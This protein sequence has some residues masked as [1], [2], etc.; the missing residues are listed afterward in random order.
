[1]ILLTRL[2]ILT[3]IR[4]LLFCLHLMMILSPPSQKTDDFLLRLRECN[5]PYHDLIKLLSFYTP[6]QDTLH[7]FF[8]TNNLTACKLHYWIWKKKKRTIFLALTAASVLQS[9]EKKLW[10]GQFL[11]DKVLSGSRLCPPLEPAPLPTENSAVYFG[12]GSH[13]L[14]H[15]EHRVRYLSLSLLPYFPRWI[16]SV[17]LFS[18]TSETQKARLILQLSPWSNSKL[19]STMWIWPASRGIFAWKHSTAG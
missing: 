19:F 7:L 6:G 9:E 12:R 18:V 16:C 5:T 1:M 13:S 14:V 17:L 10:L 2:Y 11:K 4:S 8:K 15:K 3:W